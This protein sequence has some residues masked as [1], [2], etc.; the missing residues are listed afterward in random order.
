MSDFETLLLQ[1]QR[2]PNATILQFFLSK[3]DSEQIV[4]VVEG[5]DDQPFYFDF[6]ADYFP[7]KSIFFFHCSGKPSLLAL[8]AFLES[9]KL[10]VQPERLL[11]LADKDFDDYLQFD[12][13]GVHKTRG[14]SIESYFVDPKYFEYIL[15]KFGGSQLSN[16]TIGELVATFEA[17]L[18]V[19]VRTTIVPMAVLC[20]IRSFNRS[21]DFDSIS[22]ADLVKVSTDIKPNRQRRTKALGQLLRAGESVDF[23]SVLSL[24]RKFQKDDFSLWLRGKHG[25][26]LARAVSRIVGNLHP[27]C[28]GALQILS[29]LLGTEAFRQAKSFL[30][31]LAGLRQYCLGPRVVHAHDDGNG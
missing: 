19:A 27:Q 1:E 16:K 31:D 20:A 10:G 26:Q 15:R 5:P 29:S 25:L 8:K 22:C 2:N 11:F 21:A 14:Y 17:N 3:Y 6:L 28:K 13:P 23:H 12:D 4:V 30:G 7:G 9:Y 24:A 18:K